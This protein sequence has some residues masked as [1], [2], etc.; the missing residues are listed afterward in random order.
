MRARFGEGQHRR[1][2]GIR[3]LEHLAP[4]GLGLLPESR[5][6]KPAQLGPARTLVLSGKVLAREAKA[7][8]EILVELRLDGADRHVLAVLR[9]VD[10]VPGR[11]GVQ[12]IDA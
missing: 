4:L 2:A 10:V 5:L 1:K 3:P 11:T 7:R 9:L 8:N 6:E 12:D